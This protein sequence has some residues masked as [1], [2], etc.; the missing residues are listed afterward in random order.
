MKDS[1]TFGFASI[2]FGLAGFFWETAVLGLV[3]SAIGAVAGFSS[4]T[5]SNGSG[6]SIAGLV[7]SGIAIF[8]NLAYL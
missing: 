8:T 7:I 6:L 3:L 5:E 4:Y 1:D 2:G